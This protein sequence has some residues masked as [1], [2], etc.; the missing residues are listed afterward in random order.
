MK[1]SSVRRL[2]LQTRRPTHDLVIRT[3]PD[4]V[5][6]A[7]LFKDQLAIP[8]RVVPEALSK[9]VCLSGPWYGERK[10]PR[11]RLPEEMPV[12][13]SFFMPHRPDPTISPTP[14][15]I[16]STSEPTLSFL[17][18]HQ[19][20][21]LA[22]AAASLNL[23]TPSSPASKYLA[24]ISNALSPVRGREVR[25]VTVPLGNGLVGGV[26]VGKRARCFR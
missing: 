5:A 1:I 19:R 22:S 8:I 23:C 3:E 16:T 10:R 15:H 12:I 9:G 17:K 7:D 2:N 18:T 21:P 4:P 11:L 6:H 25:W 26:A 14:K 20:R 13:P 24:G